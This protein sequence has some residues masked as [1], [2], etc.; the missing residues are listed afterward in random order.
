MIELVP[1]WHPVWVHFTVGLLGG[2]V[3]FY[4]LAFIGRGSDWGRGALSAGRWALGAGIVFA[5]LALITGL[6]AAGNL[7]HDDAAHANM[8]VHRN[9]AFGTTAVFVLTAIWML[10]RRRS[11]HASIGVLLLAVVGLTGL[12]VTGYEGGENVFEH[13]LG[14]QR[15]PDAGGHD[16]AAHGHGSDDA[17]SQ[18]HD[19]KGA[20]DDRRREEPVSHDHGEHD[21]GGGKGPDDEEAHDDGAHDHG[22]AA[23]STGAIAGGELA[24][25]AEALAGALAA[26]DEA[27]VRE[28]LA[29]N[30]LIF[31]SG[32]AE[33]SL[34]E[35]A[36]HHMGA[37]MK[38]L[39]AIQREVLE[40]KVYR[41]DGT[42][43]VATRSRLHG[44]YGDRAIDLISTETLA[45]EQRDGAWKIVHIH[46]AS[47]EGQ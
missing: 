35:Y 32:G 12:T 3:L 29:E 14:V 19:G 2:G 30:V 11:E 8:L 4:L 37:D 6:W 33:R 45:L 24:D 10:V 17:E 36:G 25:Q 15:L 7:P 21:H 23:A 34:E 1:N 5:G 43:V 13:G 39:A 18:G 41:G 47:A 44:A 16:H 20:G 28:L 42:G 22:S 38:F 31:E 26:G 40:R 46:W 9:W 27:R